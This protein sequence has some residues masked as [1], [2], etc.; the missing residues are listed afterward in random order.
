M[1]RR[2]YIATLAI[3]LAIAAAAIPGA[4]AA[5][6]AGDAPLADGG[7]L[8]LGSLFFDVIDPALVEDPTSAFA[9]SSVL[10]AWAVEDATCTMLLRYPTGAPTRQDYGL[11]PEV[12][13]D[14]PAVPPDGKTYTF[15]IRPGFRF[16]DG[17]PVT[18]ANYARA[19]KR[20]LD[21]RMGSPAAK[22]LQEVVGVT[23]ASNRLIVRLATSVPDFPAR[24]TMPYFCPVAKDLPIVP[25][26]VGAPL[27]GSGPYYIA[28]F[29][30]GKQVVLKR[31]PFYRGSRSH[32]VDQ[33]VVE[34]GEDPVAFS[35]KVEAVA[36]D[37]DL[38]VPL[39]RLPELGARYAVNKDQL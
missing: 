22:Y 19:I 4:G 36:A 34:V 7:T 12:A 29:V 15:V 2:L 32:H 6:R 38:N 37:V 5:M 25:E 18:A 3:A 8:V 33:F 17:A 27:P 11:V 39:P 10:A 28:E 1:A 26:G 35:R 20:V 21:P 30:R 24:M 9:I 16:S 13:A 23:F 31:N 14:Y